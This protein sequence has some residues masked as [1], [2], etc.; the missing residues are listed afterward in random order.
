MIVHEWRWNEA[1]CWISA[2]GPEY[3]DTSIENK[4]SRAS[5]RGA[6]SNDLRAVCLVRA[7]VD[8]SDDV[9]DEV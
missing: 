4:V 9:F 7:I 6:T 5:D 2:K 8:D 3:R 1:S